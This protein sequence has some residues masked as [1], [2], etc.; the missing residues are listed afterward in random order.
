M[1]LENIYEMFRLAKSIEVE[2]QSVVTRVWGEG[3]IRS[4]YYGY[5]AS[6]WANEV[7]WIR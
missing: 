6:L 7:F 2:S 1:N 5:G 3:G 4:D